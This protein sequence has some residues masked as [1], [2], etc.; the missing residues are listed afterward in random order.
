MKKSIHSKESSLICD[1]IRAMRKESGLTQ[2][3]LSKILEREHSFI[4]KIEI[5]E[6][7]I[8]LVE[9][10]NISK[11]CGADPSIIARSLFHSFSDFE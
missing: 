3:D 5:G 8:D 7:R 2:R 4:A 9:F 6:R 10:Y 11:A 1:S